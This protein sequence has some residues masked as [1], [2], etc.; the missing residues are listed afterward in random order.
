M[1]IFAL[2]FASRFIDK[3]LIMS[4]IKSKSQPDARRCKSEVLKGVKLS[5]RSQGRM[6]K[7]DIEEH[8][9]FRHLVEVKINP[10]IIKA[11]RKGVSYTIERQGEIVE[12]HGSKQ[13]TIGRVSKSDVQVSKGKVYKLTR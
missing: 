11:K 7:G 3:L 4:K 1:S 12:I 9:C 10:A 5:V 6:A 2:L 13:V 8:E